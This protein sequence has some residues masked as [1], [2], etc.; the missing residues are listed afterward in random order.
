MKRFFTVVV[1]FLSFFASAVL[2]EP[3][4]NEEEITNYHAVIEPQRDGSIIVSEFITVNCLYQNIKRGIFRDLPEKDGVTYKVLSVRRD[5]R[6]EP[7]FT[8]K[9]GRNKRVNTG[10]DA[11][12]PQRGLYTYEIRYKARDVVRG[13]DDFDEVYWN[14]TGNGWDFPISNASAEIRLPLNVKVLQ[15]AAYVGFSGSKEEGKLSGGYFSAGR[16]LRAHEGLTVA[17]GFEKG[18]VTDPIQG[19]RPFETPFPPVWGAVCLVLIYASA[20]WFLFGRDPAPLTVMPQFTAPEGMTAAQSGYVYFRGN[21]EGACFA[22]ALIE[23]AQKGLLRITEETSSFLVGRLRR[24]ENGEEKFLEKNVKFP[25]RLYEAYDSSLVVKVAD[26]ERFL[27]E[28]TADYFDKNTGFVVFGVFLILM[29][30][31]A[32]LYLA[33]VAFSQELFA[34]AIFL[35]SGVS[36]V[37]S[38]LR[39]VRARKKRYMK[40]AISL[41]F[42]ILFLM[43]P[44]LFLR[45]LFNNPQAVSA[46]FFLAGCLALSP[47]YAYLMHR[48]SV[49]GKRLEEYLDGLKMFMTAV[50]QDFPKEATFEKMDKLLPYAVLFGIEK[51][52]IEKTQQMMSGAQYQPT[53]YVSSR[54]FSS[55]DIYLVRGF[56]SSTL[57]PPA[58]SG[59]FSGS[60]G[61]GFSGGG[62]GGGGGGG[63]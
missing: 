61:G 31:I 48:P 63:R 11:F 16:P 4:S 59:R 43:T 29:L 14:V 21:N 5:G 52:W 2:A 7:F 55:S 39:P 10:T 32:L 56:V 23:G 30:T 35:F 40:R 53:W 3:L 49:K 33:D 51:E 46:F 13:F 45:P 22:A 62:F 6:P 19:S 54:P 20:T 27:K 60:G 8:E 24:G 58:S 18:F 25:L 47:F 15:K 57:T 42:S 1:A 12:L 17:A 26:F 9:K 50:H 37:F 28:K 41:L 36:G 44:V 38:A 34:G